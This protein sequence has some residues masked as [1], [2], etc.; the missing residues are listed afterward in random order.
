VQV[1][2]VTKCV[3][4]C[5]KK[6][7]QEENEKG[8]FKADAQHFEGTRSRWWRADRF[9]AWWCHRRVKGLGFRFWVLGFRGSGLRFRVS[10]FRFRV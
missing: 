1:W 2:C 3:M 9:T 5:R 6:D 7:E 4:A 10:G 8:L